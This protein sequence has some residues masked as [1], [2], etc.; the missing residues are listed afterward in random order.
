MQVAVFGRR[1][2]QQFD[3]RPGHGVGVPLSW[4]LGRLGR[5][6]SMQW[7][8]EEAPQQGVREVRHG[9]LTGP[10]PAWGAVNAAA[11]D[12]VSKPGVHGPVAAIGLDIFGLGDTEAEVR[13][14]DEPSSRRP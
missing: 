7:I 13:G 4:D 3:R 14:V 12:A 10:S 11:P 1:G 9:V 6:F 2:Q 8:V 5:Q